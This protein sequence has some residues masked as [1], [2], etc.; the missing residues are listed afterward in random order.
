MLA[1]RCSG[2]GTS[3][4]RAA[5]CTWRSLSISS[6]TMV[7][8]IPTMYG[9]ASWGGS[10][11]PPL[12]TC[13][14]AWRACVRS[15]HRDSAISDSPAAS[16][17]ARL[18]ASAF[19]GPAAPQASQPSTDARGR[20]RPRSRRLMVDRL[21]PLRRAASAAS[22]STVRSTLPGS[23]RPPRPTSCAAGSSTQTPGRSRC[24]GMPLRY[25]CPPRPS[26]RRPVRPLSVRCGSTSCP[27]S[28]TRKASAG[29]GSPSWRAVPA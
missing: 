7:P 14:Q 16:Q 26:A 23:R 8:R 25:G 15:L 11:M 19:S 13:R 3:P 29:T 4:E 10:W 27:I 18:T 12:S 28:A 6:G 9:A 20:R 2:Q 22:R 1:I 24:G 5:S 17:S 21:T